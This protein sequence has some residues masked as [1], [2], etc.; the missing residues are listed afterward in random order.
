MIRPTMEEARQLAQ[1]YTVVPIAM[2]LFS[3]QK[4]PIE[5][6]RVIRQK[7][8]R[9]Y[10]LESV[11]GSDT[12]G[13]YSF[14]GYDPRLTVTGTDGEV[15]IRSDHSVTKKHGTPQEIL[16]EIL[17]DYRSP[18]VNGLPPFTGGFVG[19][20]SYDCVK[21]FEPSLTL[22]AENAEGFADFSLMLMDKVIA[23]DHFRQKIYL[24][25][26][27]PA[28]DLENG[29]IK[30]VTTL[31]D[32]ERLILEPVPAE[33]V[34]S[35][36]CGDFTAAFSE[37]AYCAMVEK[38][39]HYIHEGDIFQVVLSNRLTAP[40]E[41]SLLG[42]YRVLRTVNPSPY[43]VFYHA[44]DVEI[45][46]ASPETLV[47]LK[48]GTVSTF[49]L[50]GTCP[51][52]KTPEEDAALVKALLQ[53][54]KELAEHNMLVDLGRNDLG[55][56]SDF[57]TVSVEEYCGIKQFSHVS[58]IAS[59]I[60]G[61]QRSDMDALDAIAATLPAG[62]LSGAPKK[63]AC[64]IIDE[65]EGQKRGVYGGAMGYIDFAGN[66]DMCIGI[67][68][69]VKKNGKVFVQSG[70]GIVAGSNPKAEYQETIN[71]AKATMA[72]LAYREE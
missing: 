45:A 1:G 53:N 16:R 58:H 22:K 39:K 4:T 59:R 10:I 66:M 33:P 42:A 54:E 40:F 41:G 31:K 20:L 35:P 50:A 70:G 43:M 60:T 7:S 32:M 56:V 65:L 19:Y 47:S 27:I 13:R 48:D 72:A 34:R 61:R 18:R 28:N 52:G 55:K 71:K 11:K 37:E 21:Y 44:D 3:D 49:P 5:L 69:A 62:T 9:F 25:V 38:A 24:I 2:E 63:R 17:A 57:G 23:F 51:R 15:E 29:Y 6:L 64:E 8:S 36:G 67:R 14:L 30:G 46:C 12:W 26:N 68:M